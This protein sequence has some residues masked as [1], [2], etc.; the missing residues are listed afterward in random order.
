MI[1]QKSMEEFETEIAYFFGVADKTP[2][3]A[4]YIEALKKL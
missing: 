2:V 1:E 4:A 3:V